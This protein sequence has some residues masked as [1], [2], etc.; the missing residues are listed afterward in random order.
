MGE[1]GPARDV[2]AIRS[3]LEQERA[4]AASQLSALER[5]HAGIVDAAADV[6]TDDEHDPD[7]ATIAFERAQLGAVRDQV[8][9]HLADL[10]AALAALAAGS[11]GVCERCGDAIAPE[12]LAARP[13]ARRCM[14]CAT[15]LR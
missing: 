9:R 2:V 3:T 15:A 12:R 10:D 5:D 14:R 4:V 11:Y 7:G 6:A 1:A 8:L 13:A